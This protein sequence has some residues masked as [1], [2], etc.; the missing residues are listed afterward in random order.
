[1][2]PSTY[3]R[4]KTIEEALQLL[5]QPGTAVL[6]GGT[7]LL[8]GDITAEAVV[9]LQELGLDQ[10]H[11]EDGKLHVGAMGR[12]VDWAA[13]LAENSTPNSPGPL[14]QKAIHQ[15]GPNTYRNAATAGGTVA[16]RLADSELLA[17]ML[18][19]DATLLL[20]TPD[21]EEV[22]LAEYLGAEE[23]PK[24]LIT[25]VRLSWESGRGES[26][27]VAR[28][29]ADYP[30]VSVTGWQPAGQHPYLAA[31]GIDKRPIRLTESEALLAAG[32]TDRA[33]EAAARRTLHPGDFR[34]DTSYRTEMAALLT[35]RLLRTINP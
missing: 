28:T 21:T 12:L 32:E 1:M 20:L 8:A 30:I 34:G 35:R 16:A 18:V 33:I 26:E 7:K 17:A 19:L 25:E 24:S 29:P 23:R 5:N 13:F 2:K 31:T 15:A 11:I 3:Y 27:R 22:S 4:P 10:L 6:A 9:D 14:L